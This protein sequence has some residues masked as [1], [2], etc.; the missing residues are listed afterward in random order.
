MAASRPPLWTCCCPTSVEREISEVPELLQPHDGVD[1]AGID[2]AFRTHREAMHRRELP[3]LSAAAAGD[4]DDLARLAQE[5]PDV[6]VLPVGVVEPGLRA[7]GRHTGV[8]CRSVAPRAA[9]GEELLHE[10][11]VP[12]EHL[13]A[14]AHAVADVDQA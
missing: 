13:D 3:G 14:V 9:L 4:A 8:V 6:L 2:V 7:V 5:S 1:L 11:A 10:G 12:A